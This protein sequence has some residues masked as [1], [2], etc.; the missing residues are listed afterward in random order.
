VTSS[1]LEASGPPDERYDGKVITSARVQLL[2]SAYA[3]LFVIL[4]IRFQGTALKWVCGILAGVGVAHLIFVLAISPRLSAA[5]S[6]PVSEVNDAG[7]EVAGFLPIYLLPFVAVPSPSVG[8]IVSYIIFAAVVAA[9][10]IRSNLAQ[11]NPTLYLI[12]WRVASVQVNGSTRY[13]VCRRIPRSPTVIRC[14]SYAG[15]LIISRRDT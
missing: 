3:P 10:F 9:I 14:H 11:I 13:L 8:D 5:R 2:L 6:Y 4:A 15:L 1:P 7:G 12:G